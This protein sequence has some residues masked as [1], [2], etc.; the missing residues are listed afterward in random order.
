MQQHHV[1]TNLEGI[2]EA[3]LPLPVFRH[4]GYAPKS[5]Q[6]SH[7]SSITPLSDTFH[8]GLQLNHK[9]HGRSI[10][11]CPDLILLQRNKLSI[12][13]PDFP[14]FQNKMYRELTTFKQRSK[15]T[16]RCVLNTQ[17]LPL[18]VAHTCIQLRPIKRQVLLQASYRNVSIV[19]NIHSTVL[20]TP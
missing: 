6:H 5:G 2:T 9:H 17:Q 14:L 8:L 11:L 12:S 19:C 7:S 1:F 13:H 15:Y 20:C 16:T 10:R 4:S 3:P 18:Q